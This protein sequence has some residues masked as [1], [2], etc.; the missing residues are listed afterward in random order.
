ML[1]SI[2]TLSISDIIEEEEVSL[3][4]EPDYTN[5]WKE[6]ATGGQR[7]RDLVSSLQV[8]GDYESLLVPPVSVISAAN[9]AAAKAIMFVSGRTGGSGILESTNML[10]KTIS[11]GKLYMCCFKI[12]GPHLL[13]K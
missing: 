6:K 4:N 3:I 12:P 13:S 9:L 7:R 10:D 2:T 5:P 11:C 8:L 1:L